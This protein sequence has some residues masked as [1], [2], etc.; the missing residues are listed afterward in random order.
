M[1]G[2]LCNAWDAA[3]QMLSKAQGVATPFSFRTLME[4]HVAHQLLK[5]VRAR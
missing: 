5:P 2:S 3:I 1:W 4:G